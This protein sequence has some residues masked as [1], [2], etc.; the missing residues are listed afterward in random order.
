MRLCMS[1]WFFWERLNQPYQQ[2][3]KRETKPNWTNQYYGSAFQNH[4]FMLIAVYFLGTGFKAGSNT[5]F[6][7]FHSK[8]SLKL[9]FL[10]KPDEISFYLEEVKNHV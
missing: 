2:E 4:F 6:E 10:L 1:Q 9:V 3:K 8:C 7:I 5:G